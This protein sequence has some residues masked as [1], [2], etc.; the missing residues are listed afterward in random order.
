MGVSCQIHVA[1][2]TQCNFQIYTKL[3]FIIEE[4]LL[5][6]TLDAEQIKSYLELVYMFMLNNS[7]DLG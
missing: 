7:F 5:N 2:G 3:P 1:V 6:K 4:V